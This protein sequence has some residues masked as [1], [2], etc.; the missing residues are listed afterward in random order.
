MCLSQKSYFVVLARRKHNAN[1]LVLSVFGY[2]F[3][4][5]KFTLICSRRKEM[6]IFHFNMKCKIKNK[7]TYESNELHFFIIL[8][9]SVIIFIVK[10]DT[11]SNNLFYIFIRWTYLAGCLKTTDNRS[12]NIFP[13]WFFVFFF[14]YNIMWTM[15]MITEWV[16]CLLLYYKTF[17]IIRWEKDC[18]NVSLI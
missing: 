4:Y 8:Q 5:R 3:H 18:K 13:L 2:V 7:N 15:K 16:L 10:E 1:W 17:K 6:W 14:S 11:F 12:L 9:F